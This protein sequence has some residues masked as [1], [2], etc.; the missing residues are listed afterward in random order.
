MSLETIGQPYMSS[1][2]GPFGT[3]VRAGGALMFG[4]MLGDRRLAAA[5]QIGNHLR[6]SAFEFRFLNQERRW[7]WGAVGELVPGLRR[8]RR[9][10]EI[11][12]DGEP[13]LLQ[14]K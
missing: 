10:G 13:A 9:F 14:A 6:D 1:G 5:V 4:D 11:E 12:H 7:N 3:F 2:G 8:Y